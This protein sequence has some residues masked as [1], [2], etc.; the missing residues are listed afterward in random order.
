MG[1]A[2][3]IR[4]QAI[5]DLLAGEQPAIV[6]E[7]YGIDQSTVRSWRRRYVATDSATQLTDATPVQRPALIAQKAHIGEL[8]IDLFTTKLKASA[9]LAAAVSD[10]VWLAKQSAAELAVLG[11]WLDSSAFAIG[12]RLAGRPADRGAE[13]PNP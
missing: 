3:E 13:E 11:Q 6:A 8:V 12:D 5:A 7:R 2:P 10:P 9:A 1:I 4:A